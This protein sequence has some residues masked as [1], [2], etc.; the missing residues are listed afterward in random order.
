MGLGLGSKKRA[1][2]KG[3]AVEVES[4]SSEIHSMQRLHV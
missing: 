1:A 4:D 3:F 2:L